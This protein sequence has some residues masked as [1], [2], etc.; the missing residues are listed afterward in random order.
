LSVP[1][2]GFCGASYQLANRYAAIERCINWYP[3]TIQSQ[4]ERKAKT[5][6]QPSP[7]N[8]PFSNFANSVGAVVGRNRALLEYRGQV[9][10]VN[11]INVVEIDANGKMYGLGVV[12]IDDGN[13]CPMVAN[14]NDQIFI[15][16]AGIGY[17]LQVGVIPGTSVLS[18]IAIQQ[19]S[20]PATDFFGASSATFQDGYILVV[21]PGSNKFQ[22]SGDDN[23][24]VGAMQVWNALKVNV[25]AGQA[26]NLRAIIS[27]REYVR[28]FGARRSQVYQNVGAAGIG[29]FPFQSYNETFI[30]TG[31]A[32]VFSLCDVGGPLFWIG[33]DARGQRAAWLDR[34]FSPERVSNYA[35]EWQWQKYLTV[36]DAWAFPLIWNGHLI[37]QITFPTADK[38]WWYDI[39]EKA[40]SER[41]YR[42]YA[43]VFHARSERTHCFAFGQHLVGSYGTD[44]NPGAIYQY[45]SNVTPPPTDPTV[46][47]R[48]SNDGGG[49]FGFE[50]SLDT[51]AIGQHSKRVYL[52]NCGYGRDRVFWLRSSELGDVGANADA[53]IGTQA[54]VRDRVC[55]HLFEGNK[56]IV[57]N[58]VEFELQ[59]ALAS[60]AGPLVDGLGVVGAE[61]DM[62]ECGS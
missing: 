48:W 41:T 26:D 31:I 40:W 58:R 32:A 18:P 38:T 59:R 54:I 33:E 35:V 49:T 29:G 36:A 20:A 22:I 52:N 10:A 19:G 25:L 61:L 42:D 57:Y 56:R 47:L 8:A 23:T 62:F 46:E 24:P 2:P 17:V 30:E 55:P 9:F 21:T 1:F 51:G 6:L 27:S 11:G 12:A 45:S 50:Y 16:S 28:L 4:D 34:S 7:G 5:I 37:I 53:S 15:A 14:A 3:E 43:G 44:G 60:G 13:P 39:T